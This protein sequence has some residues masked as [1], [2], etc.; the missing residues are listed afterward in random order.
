M[1]YNF[2]NMKKL[3][4]KILILSFFLLSSFV[5]NQNVYSQGEDP[6]ENPDDLYGYGCM[7]ET[8]LGD[9]DPRLVVI[10]II[11]FSLALIGTLCTGL[12]VYAGYL[13]MTAG[14]NDDQV[15]KAKNILFSAIIGLIIVLMAY[16]VTSFVLKSIYAST[17]NYGSIGIGV[18]GDGSIN[19]N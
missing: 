5:I 8:Q 4:F 3:N 14:G 2:F 18:T 17:Q 12:F 19:I 7:T 6:C 15:T 13:W 10:T 16:S 9:R 1:S 11:K